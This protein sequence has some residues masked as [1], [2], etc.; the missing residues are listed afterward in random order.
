MAEK[1]VITEAEEGPLAKV[2]CPHCGKVVGW[3][4]NLHPRQEGRGGGKDRLR[5][6]TRS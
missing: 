1:A 5:F 6:Y 2:H 4:D 3:K